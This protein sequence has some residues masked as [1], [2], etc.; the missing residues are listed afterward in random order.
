[1]ISNLIR[2]SPLVYGSYS[3]NLYRLPS[4]KYLPFPAGLRMKR[5]RKKNK[6]T[7]LVRIICF[8]WISK[9]EIIATSLI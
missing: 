6:E 3:K 7:P 4:V 5:L 9:L 8:V 1:M 2:Y